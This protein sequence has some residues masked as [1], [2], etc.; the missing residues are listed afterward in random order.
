MATHSR[1]L[2]WTIPWTEELAGLQ[3]MGSQRDGHNLPIEHTGTGNRSH[4]LHSPKR[5]PPSNP[6]D[7]SSVTTGWRDQMDGC[8]VKAKG[9]GMTF[10]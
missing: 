9:T 2:A 8:V 1:I 5:N 6:K 3:S 4:Q 10:P 7:N